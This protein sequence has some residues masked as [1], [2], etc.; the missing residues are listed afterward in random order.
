MAKLHKYGSYEEYVIT[1]IGWAAGNR[2]GRWMEESDM[3]FL[4]DYFKE[5]FDTS[6]FEMGICHGSKLGIENAWL[7]KHLGI[8]VWG[9]D[10][11]ARAHDPRYAH[12]K[13][14]YHDI[15]CP[16]KNIQW[17]FHNVKDEWINAVDVIYSNALDHSNDP[18]YC[19][20]QW[21]RCVKKTGACVL[22]W[23]PWHSE[24]HQNIGN[25]YGATLEEYQQLAT[26]NGF[27]VKDVLSKEFGADH[28]FRKTG[29]KHF[30]VVVHS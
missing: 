11:G 26:S 6:T 14:P 19:L 20:R 1:Q 12:D 9:T 29:L 24:N 4:A 27:K 16:V 15:I 5:N 25:P 22:E 2:H 3:K 28:Q 13:S 10:L 7:Q 30:V 23:T 8:D 18:P 21:M 17:D